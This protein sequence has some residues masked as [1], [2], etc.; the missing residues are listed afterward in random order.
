MSS[1]DAT[2]DEGSFAY[3]AYGSNLLKKRLNVNCPTAQ[4][5][6]VAKLADYQLAFS[7]RTSQRWKGSVATIIPKEGLHMWGAVWKMSNSFIEELD[8]QEWV[9]LGVYR[10]IE[11]TVELTSGE[12]LACVSYEQTNTTP[13]IPSPQYLSVIIEGA[14]EVGLPRDYIRTLQSISHNG[15]SD[16]DVDYAKTEA[17]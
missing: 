1:G 14:K 16:D 12:K 10:R 7:G 8:K 3:F 4:L 11:L 2:S 15:Y 6:G 17:Y 5:L 9:H 13:G